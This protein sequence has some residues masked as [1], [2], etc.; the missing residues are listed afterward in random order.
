[1][2]Q[3]RPF[4]ERFNVPHR[5]FYS[6]FSTDLTRAKDWY[7]ALFGYRVEF[8]S[9]WFVHLQDPANPSIEVGVIA[10]DHEIVPDG[11]RAEPTGGLLTLV[12]DDVDAIH[13]R[14]LDGGVVVVEEPRD[15]FYGQRRLLLVDPDG[16][17]VDVSS[18]CPPDPEWLAS[19]G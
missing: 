17:L 12:V 5:S 4:L 2:G 18:E 6:V 7:V 3:T 9:D 10:R 16:L 15:L 13:Q 11:F 14:A 8:E 1:M 19:L